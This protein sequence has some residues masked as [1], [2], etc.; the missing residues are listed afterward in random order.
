MPFIVAILAFTAI[1]DIASQCGVAGDACG[2]DG[3]GKPRREVHLQAHPGDHLNVHECCD[4]LQC[5]EFTCRR[6]WGQPAPT[7]TDLK[8]LYDQLAPEKGMT[9]AR[10]TQILATWQGREERL[11]TS[12]RQKYR[13]PKDEL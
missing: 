3:A 9:T 1:N 11:L 10:A 13:R 2:F 4:G 8:T 6:P 5:E 7:A 12:L